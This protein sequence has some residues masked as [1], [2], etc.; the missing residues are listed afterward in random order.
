[1]RE[2]PTEI[3]SKEE[4]DA[5]LMAAGQCRP[6]EHDGAMEEKLIAALASIGK[7]GDQEFL[8]TPAGTGSTPGL[9]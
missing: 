2:T 8:T 4:I 9:R 7:A 5:M 1:M 3:L 6:V